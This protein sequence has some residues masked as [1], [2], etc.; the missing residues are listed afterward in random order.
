[1]LLLLLLLLPPLLLQLRRRRRRRHVATAVAQLHAAAAA[2]LN[3]TRAVATHQGTPSGAAP[4]VRRPFPEPGRSGRELAGGDAWIKRRSPGAD[5][6][7]EVV[8][9]CG[10]STV[11][12]QRWRR[13]NNYDDSQD[14][15]QLAQQQQQ[16]QEP[17][18]GWRRRHAECRYVLHGQPT[19]RTP[20]TGTKIDP[21][22][23]LVPRL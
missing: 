12:P 11:A 17:E 20:Q 8:A 21:R 19:G 10:P 18:D 13:V 15:W 22:W 7:T 5:E 3:I 9:A 6:E 14:A 23:L 1:M 2:A 4:V 16:Q